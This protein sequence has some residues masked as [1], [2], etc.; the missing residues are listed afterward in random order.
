MSKELDEYYKMC[1]Y[2]TTE[3]DDTPLV[4][5]MDGGKFKMLSIEEYE[6]MTN[7]LAD[8]EAKLAESKENIKILEEQLANSIKPRFE[9]CQNVWCVYPPNEYREGF[10][11]DLDFVGYTKDKIICRITENEE[12]NYDEVFATKKE[13]LAKLKELKGE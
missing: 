1:S 6:E 9:Y 2:R 3:I 11:F 5:V 13:A 4:K 8:L 10:V 12:F 7:K